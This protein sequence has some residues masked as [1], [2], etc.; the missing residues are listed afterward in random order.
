MLYIRPHKLNWIVDL[1]WSGEAQGA[2]ADGKRS[3][4]IVCVFRCLSTSPK[5]RATTISPRTRPWGGR[6]P[7]WTWS[8][9]VLPAPPLWVGPEQRRAS[10]D[11][12]AAWRWE[13]EAL[14]QTWGPLPPRTDLKQWAEPTHHWCQSMQTISCGG[15]DLRLKTWTTSASTWLLVIETARTDDEESES[16][17]SVFNELLIPSFIATF[18]FIF[19]AETETC[20]RLFY[21]G[22]V[23]TISCSV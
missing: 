3:P 21:F 13:A 15:G 18:V 5:T 6:T 1:L 16:F 7:L 2:G 11:H 19:L 23:H 17:Q 20:M 4:D 14:G 10:C 12:D 9:W 8:C 22:E